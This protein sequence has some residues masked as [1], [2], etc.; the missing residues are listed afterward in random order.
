MVSAVPFAVKL[1]LAPEAAVV[2][3]SELLPVSVGAPI[4]A[5]PLG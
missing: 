1:L 2:Q 5:T 3:R 4:S